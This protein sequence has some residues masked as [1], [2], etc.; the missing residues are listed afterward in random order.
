MAERNEAVRALGGHDAGKPRGAQDV[1][2]HRIAFE[3]QIER[4]LAHDHAAF[5]DR[6]PFGRAFVGDIDHAGFAALVDM[7]EGARGLRRRRQGFRTSS[8]PR[9]STLRVERRS[10]S[11][12][13]DRF[14]SPRHRSLRSGTTWFTRKQGA[15]C[16]R[17]VR[18][19]H[20]AFADQE[21]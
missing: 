19:P 5:R 1:A 10:F 6:Y 18:L 11:A 15:G 16:G 2:L 8:S 7:G 14:L 3:H 13:R 9:L 20:Q 12:P 21:R 4:L 17:D